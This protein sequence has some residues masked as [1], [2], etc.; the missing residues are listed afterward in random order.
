MADSGGARLSDNP[1]SVRKAAPGDWREIRRLATLFGSAIA[2]DI[3]DEQLFVYDLGA[4][5]LGG[6][7]SVSARPWT[8]GSAARPVA[9]VEAWFVDRKLRRQGIGYK[10]MQAA[11]LWASLHGFSELCSDVEL[12][13][14]DGLAAHSRLG[15]EPT[16]RLQ[17]FRKPLGQAARRVAGQG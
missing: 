17:Y 2:L 7:I 12:G 16:L 3:W 11:E 13:N 1:V 4:G 10:L 14:A 8:E 6:F 9:H 15:F 5:R